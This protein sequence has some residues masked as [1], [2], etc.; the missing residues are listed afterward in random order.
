[1]NIKEGRQLNSDENSLS[2]IDYL[3]TIG[4]IDSGD[5]YPSIPN[6]ND[7]YTPTNVTFLPTSDC[8][9]NC[10]YCYA[11]SGIKSKYLTI[12]IAKSALDFIFN[13]AK[14][15]KVSRVQIGFLG[16]GEPFLAWSFIHEV[17][18]YARCKADQIGVSTYFTGVTNGM[19]SKEQVI[20]LTQNFQYLNISLDGMKEIQDIHR[21]TRDHKNSYETVINTIG[22]LND[23]GF[24]YAIRSTISSVS[25]DQ[26]APITEFFVYTLRASKIHFEPLFACGR[27]RTTAKLTPDPKLFAANFKQCLNVVQSTDTELFCSSVRLDSLTSTFC[28]A[29]GENFYITPEGYVTSC[30]EVSSID[31]SLSD[32]FFIGKYDEQSNSFV[33]WND[34]R[35]YLANRTVFNMNSC[36]KCIAKWHCAGG[37]PVKAAYK[38]DIFNSSQL[39]NCKIARELTEFHIRAFAT[40]KE[41]S[42]PRISTKRIAQ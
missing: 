39:D 29:L 19:L 14:E 10:I 24:R 40:H 42:F 7:E 21:P 2:V 3:K 5:T 41:L 22:T 17:L 36:S 30:T 27:C 6:S 11:N 9:L 32:M 25:I 4:I 15:K 28:G 12:D 38:G 16:G 31:E 1:M 23:A 26:M 37:C 8:N 35:N 20:W 33:F 13:N 18:R 34:K